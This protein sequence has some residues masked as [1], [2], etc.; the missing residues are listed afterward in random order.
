MT[1]NVHSSEIHEFLRRCLHG[2]GEDE[3]QGQ[4][5]SIVRVYSVGRKFGMTKA[6][7]ITDPTNGLRLNDGIGLFVDDDLRE[8]M[9]KVQ[10]RTAEREPTYKTTQLFS[11]TLGPATSD[12]PR[13]RAP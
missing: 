13:T 5:E 1:R 10:H 3:G 4:G 6:D 12:E 9:V 8:H 2:A 11:R 7:I